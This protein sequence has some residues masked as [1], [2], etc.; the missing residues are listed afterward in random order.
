MSKIGYIKIK[1]KHPKVHRSGV[2]CQRYRFEVLISDEF[3]K[4]TD[5][6]LKKARLMHLLSEEIDR[7]LEE[8]WTIV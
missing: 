3:I 1:S 2:Y 4:Y 5:K 8:G 7:Q 6:D